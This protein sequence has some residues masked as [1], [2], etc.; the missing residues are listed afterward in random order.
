MALKNADSYSLFIRLIDKS[1]KQPGSVKVGSTPKDKPVG[2]K[3]RE[4][5]KAQSALAFVEVWVDTATSD[6][7]FVYDNIKKAREERKW[8]PSPYQFKMNLLAPR[9]GFSRPPRVPNVKDQ[10]AVAAIH[11]RYA[12]MRESVTRTPATGE[13][14]LIKS[15][16]DSWE[17]CRY[18]YLMRSELPVGAPLRNHNDI[19]ADEV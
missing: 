9:F 6:T 8:T 18:N 17:T 19:A 14:S 13:L 3:G 1:A 7:G 5:K 10:N 4:L 16:V 11:D 2:L 12:L 15:D